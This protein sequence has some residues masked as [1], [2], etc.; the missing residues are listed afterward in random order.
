MVISNDTDS[1]ES[2]LLAESWTYT[3]INDTCSSEVYIGSLCKPYLQVWKSC[4]AENNESNISLLP[5]S[6][7]QIDREE[8]LNS[9]SGFLSKLLYAHEKIL[10]NL[11]YATTYR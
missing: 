4:V 8:T 10:T 2:D 9:L 1:C 11:F 5:M 3:S 7:S 6:A